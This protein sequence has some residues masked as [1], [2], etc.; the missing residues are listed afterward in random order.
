MLKHPGAVAGTRLRGTDMSE[1]KHAQDQFP[2]RHLEAQVCLVAA[3]LIDSA[4]LSAQTLPRMFE[5][6]S[7]FGHF[8]VQAYDVQ[9]L[10]EVT[11]DH[12]ASFVHAHRRDHVEASV[13]TMHLRR[14]ALRLLFRTARRL[15]MTDAD[16]T[17]DLTLDARSGVV[18][19]PLTDDEAAVCRTAAL[20]SLTSTR[21]SAAWA[22]AEATART[23]ELPHLRLCDL[24]LDAG[25]V[26]IHGSPRTEPRWGVLDEW[27]A[28]QLAR[29]IR[30]LGRDPDPETRLVYAGSGSAQSQ[31]ASSCQAIGE[32][33]RRAGLGGEADVRPISVVGWASARI[34]A[35][36]GRIETAARALGVRSL[37]RAVRLIGL[38]W[39]R[40]ADA[41]A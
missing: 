37:D 5:L 6:I 14:S 13:A 34:F 11:T 8:A 35:E 25:R 32:T 1:H 30:D 9:G 29:H 31:Q 3:E 12:V 28:R 23:A 38:D 39:Q 2:P 36:T 7:R 41:P 24:D 22:L 17:V 33:L 10:D 19:R 15:G 27:G 4:V 26:W 16:P 20:H 21:L 18:G 40:T